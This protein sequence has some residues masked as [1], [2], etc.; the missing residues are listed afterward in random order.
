MLWNSLDM[1][2]LKLNNFPA[3]FT[4]DRFKFSHEIQGK[5]VWDVQETRGIEEHVVLFTATILDVM[6]VIIVQR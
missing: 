6:T 2:A 5:S 4:H 3:K 1:T